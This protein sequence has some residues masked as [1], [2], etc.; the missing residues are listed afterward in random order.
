MEP[1]Y[2]CPYRQKHGFSKLPGQSFPHILPK[3][4]LSPTHTVQRHTFNGSNTHL[5][6]HT[7]TDRRLLYGHPNAQ[8]E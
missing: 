4:W 8:A 5:L 1:L 6:G 7:Q 3:R 2:L